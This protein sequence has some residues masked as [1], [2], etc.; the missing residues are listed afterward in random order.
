M[1]NV[2]GLLPSNTKEGRVAILVK[3]V[4][5]IPGLNAADKLGPS[6]RNS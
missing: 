2:R 5:S 3:V 4:W 1:R 6:V